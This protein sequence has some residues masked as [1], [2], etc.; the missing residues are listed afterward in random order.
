MA[1][2]KIKTSKVSFVKKHFD[3]LI[4]P[5]ASQKITTSKVYFNAIFDV[6][7]VVVLINSKDIFDVLIST[8]WST[9]KTISTFWS[10]WPVDVLIVDVPT[11]SHKNLN[12]ILLLLKF[13]IIYKTGNFKYC[14]NIF[15]SICYYK[16][17]FFLFL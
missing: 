8:F 17:F 7:I 4:L 10:F 9:K 14:Y 13:F 5:M 1:S 3:V 15:Y 2:Q 6:L 16:F 11:P 12:K